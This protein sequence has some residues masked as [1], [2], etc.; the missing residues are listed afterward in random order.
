MSKDDLLALR[1]A[2]CASVV[3]NAGEGYVANMVCPIGCSSP[4]CS[5]CVRCT[6]CSSGSK[7]FR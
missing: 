4:N 7:A 6:R 2:L 3:G 5:M 1:T